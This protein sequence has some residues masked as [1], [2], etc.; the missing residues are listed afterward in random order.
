MCEQENQGS[1]MCGLFIIFWVAMA[2]LIEWVIARS[3]PDWRHRVP[4]VFANPQPQVDPS[5][6][7]L[8]GRLARGEIDA[9]EYERSSRVLRG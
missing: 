4:G 5:E 9:E 1:E 7:I 8:R 2:A 6:E 3:G